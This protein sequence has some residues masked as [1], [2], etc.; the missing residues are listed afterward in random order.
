MILALWLLA[1]PGEPEDT[2]PFAV[3]ACVTCHTGIE[4]AHPGFGTTQ[5][6]VC[7][8][9]DGEAVEKKTAHVPVPA[10]WA[11]IRGTAL[12]PSPEGFIKDFA[13]DQL[14]QLPAAYVR[15]INPGDIRAVSQ[16]CGLCHPEH[17]AN[18]LTSV[19]TT[20]AGHYYPTLLLAGLQ[21]DRL[22]RYGS[23]GAEDP[24]CDPDTF[25]GSVCELDQI[26]PQD[27]TFLKEVAE[28][29][30]LQAVREV[31]Y[32]H[33]LSKNCNTCHQAGYPRNDSPGLYRSSGCTSCHMVYDT[34]GTYKGDDPVL[35]RGTPTHP[36]THQITTAIPTEQ[37]ASCHFQGG[38]IGLAYQGIREGGFSAET[39]PE[40]AEFVSSTLYGHAPGY[41]LSDEDT[42]NAVDETPPD[43]HHDAGMVCVDCH[44]GTDV[45]GN[46]RIYSTSKQQVD[47]ACEDCHGTI[48]TPVHPGASGF[49]ETAAGRP[50][51]QLAVA[52]DGTVTLTDRMAG[53]VHPVAQ[54]HDVVND[55]A[56]IAAHAAMSRYES[57]F[58]HTEALTCDT[59]HSG[60]QQTCVGCHVTVDF[61]LKQVDYQTGLSSPG[62]TRGSRKLYSLD[63]LLLG[64]R[65]DG[66][67]QSVQASQQLQMLVYGSSE[68]GWE[69]GE[70]VLGATVAAADGTS[71]DVGEWRQPGG[72]PANNGFT[73]FFQHTTSRAP[74]GCEACH[75][76]A[77]TEAERTRIKGVLG[78]GTGEYMLLGSDGVKVDGLQFLDAN[79][80][81]ITT[82]VHEG[83][84][85]L[86][87]AMQSS[88][89][90][91]VVVP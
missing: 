50:L 39:T 14:D 17:A 30:D 28:S 44:T 18:Q 57:G 52:G 32:S 34:D 88:L 42:T 24:D 48:D 81:Q 47:I 7:H 38:R 53:A 65:S 13:P 11:T 91:T 74:R 2:S 27:T 71:T 16:T 79:G 66:R 37:C 36:R 55:P 90:S 69:D 45:H 56:R 78:Y 59:C 86:S 9:G 6:V 67:V 84:G 70:V 46:G 41:Y 12:P 85:A 19:M 8:G 89:L 5:C 40:N 26:R 25:P 76:A 22:A 10:E 60:W 83:T 4:L 72:E 68:F 63:S 51:K 49:V 21:D 43:L 1:C 73:P 33:Y 15:F 87:P 54:V 29:G 3:D 61:R 80:D 23:Y 31:A 77:D 82:W 75:L 20:N 58:S 35:P 62:L 64:V